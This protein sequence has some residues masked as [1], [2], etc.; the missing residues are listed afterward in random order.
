LAVADFV[1]QLST[2]Q[3]L[4]PEFLNKVENMKMQKYSHAVIIAV[5]ECCDWSNYIPVVQSQHSW[6]DDFL[7]LCAWL[8]QDPSAISSKYK[9]FFYLKNLRFSSIL[10]KGEVVFHKQKN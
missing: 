4:K 2:V 9:V 7:Q 10:K 5:M 1:Q 8:E 6:Y 3:I